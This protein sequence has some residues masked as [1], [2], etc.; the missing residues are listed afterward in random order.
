MHDN[1]TKGC[2]ITTGLYAASGFTSMV[3]RKKPMRDV[4]IPYRVKFTG[5]TEAFA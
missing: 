5:S 2:Q 4:T 1:E 3:S